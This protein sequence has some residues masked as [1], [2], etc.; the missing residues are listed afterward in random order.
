MNEVFVLGSPVIIRANEQAGQV[1]GR[2]E[3]LD[4]MYPVSYWVEHVDGDGDLVRRWYDHY[5]LKAN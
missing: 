5:Q 4:D 1:I 2:A 3:Y